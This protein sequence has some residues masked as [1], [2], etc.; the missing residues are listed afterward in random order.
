[1]RDSSRYC[2]GGGDLN[3]I[4]SPI[5]GAFLSYFL[6]HR[7]K[8]E[9]AKMAQGIS[10]VHLYNS[11]LEL[12]Q[13]EVPSSEEKIKIVRFMASLETTTRTIEKQ[14]KQS[15]TWKKGLLQQMFV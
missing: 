5:N 13:I 14:I 15:Q 11:Q 12:L 1:M 9:L 3:I 10:V 8:N 4:R 7:C 6:K 2:F